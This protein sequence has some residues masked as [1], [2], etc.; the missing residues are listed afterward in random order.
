MVAGEGI[1]FADLFAEDG[2]LVYPFSLPGQPA[3]LRGREAIRYVLR[4]PEP[5]P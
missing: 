4:C 5:E 3:E 1:D 2:L